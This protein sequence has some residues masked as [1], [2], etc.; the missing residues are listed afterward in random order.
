MLRIVLTG[1]PGS[2]K[3]TIGSLIAAAHPGHYVLL[4]EAAT[5]VYAQLGARWDRLDDAERQRVQRLIYALQLEQEARAEREHPHKVHLLDRGTADGAVYWPAGP[6]DYWR[7]LNTTLQDQYARYD[8]VIW[9]ESCAAIGLYDGATSNAVRHEDAT[10]AIATG[11]RVREVWRAHPH[12]HQI[13]AFVDID[14]KRAQVMEIV[15]SLPM[16]EP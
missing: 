8:A 1:G 4:P 6:E 15:R 5:Q 7:Q 3:T 10:T 9:L 12:F 13:R 14:E 2:G 16:G 11:K